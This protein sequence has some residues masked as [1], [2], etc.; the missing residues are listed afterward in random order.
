MTA[1]H[2]AVSGPA[3]DAYRY[4]VTAASRDSG[5]ALDEGKVRVLPRS[6]THMP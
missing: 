6:G 3:A 5:Q 4:R 1:D 2:A